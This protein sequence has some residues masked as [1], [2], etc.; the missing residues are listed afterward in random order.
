MLLHVHARIPKFVP[1]SGGSQTK[2]ASLKEVYRLVESAGNLH[3]FSVKEEGAFDRLISAVYKFPPG[4]DPMEAFAEIEK[5]LRQ[6]F[7]KVHL[8]LRGVRK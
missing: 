6:S 8:E 1:A 4:K 7:G 3:S 2:F 5:A